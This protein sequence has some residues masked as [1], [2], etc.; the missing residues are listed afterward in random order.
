MTSGIYELTFGRHGNYIGKSIDID[1]RWKQHWDKL[2]KGTAAKSLQEAFSLNGGSFDAKIL[3]ECHPDHIDIMEECL[4]ARLNP[5]LNT[6]RPKDRLEGIVG[7]DFNTVI[8]FFNMSTVDHVRELIQ[9]KSQ[10]RYARTA[11]KN[12]ETQIIEL[13]DRRS[14]EELQAD[15]SGRIKELSEEVDELNES[16]D[17]SE[18][19][20]TRLTEYSN[21]L[22]K[23]LD[24]AKL[25]WWQKLFK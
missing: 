20:I 3:F 17:E 5:T 25:S 16:L 18:E 21:S 24:Y 1:A 2:S 6:T 19:T 10:A 15:I 22:R 13:L 8:Q 12:C 23:D 14:A 4:I 11:L 7:D 9:A